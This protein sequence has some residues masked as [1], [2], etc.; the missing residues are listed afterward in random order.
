MIYLLQRLIDAWRAHRRRVDA[1]GLDPD[2]R[3]FYRGRWR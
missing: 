2:F 1:E 3:A